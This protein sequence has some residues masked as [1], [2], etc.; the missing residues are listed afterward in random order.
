MDALAFSALAEPTRLKIVELLRDRPSSVNQIAQ[1][2]D[3]RQP[4]T[5]KHLQTLSRAGIVSVR[6]VAQQR[7]YVLRPEAF[8][9]ISAWLGSF[10]RHWK[11]SFTR[12]DAYLDT[13]AQQHQGATTPDE[14]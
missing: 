4:Q 6:P 12:L 10:E 2:L 11:D 8:R 9:D 3:L 13:T 1:Q 14:H 5:S 7:I